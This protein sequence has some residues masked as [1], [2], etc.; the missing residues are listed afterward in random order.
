MTRL[1]V[2][3]P[4]LHGGEPGQIGRIFLNGEPID[5]TEHLVLKQGD[6][7]SMQTAGGGAFGAPG[8]RAAS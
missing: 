5:P 4:G 7:V 6:V 8:A 1:K 2:P 3:P